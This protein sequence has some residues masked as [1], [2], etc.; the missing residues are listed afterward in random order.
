MPGLEQELRDAGLE[1]RIAVA[2]VWC[3]R[4]GAKYLEEIAECADTFQDFVEALELKPL[5]VRRLQRG[6]LGKIGAGGILYPLRQPDKEGYSHP[7]IPKVTPAL[8]IGHTVFVKNTFI[9]LDDGLRSPRLQ[10]ASTYHVRE[11]QADSDEEEQPDDAG[12]TDEIPEEA[13]ANLSSPRGTA[14]ELTDTSALYKTMTVDGYEPSSEWPWLGDHPTTLASTPE[15]GPAEV[16][17]PFRS[18]AMVPVEAYGPFV[19]IPTAGMCFPGHVSVELQ[20]FDRWPVPNLQQQDLPGTSSSSTQKRPQ[21][22]QRAFS[23]A[24]RICRIRWTVDARKLRST[25]R[26]AVSPPFDLSYAGPVTFKMIM[27]PKAISSERGGSCFKRSRGRGTIELRCMAESDASERP[28]VTFRIGVGSKEKPDKLRGPVRHDFS[29]KLICGLP[30]GQAIWDFSKT[31]DEVT[32]TFVVCLE[33]MSE[34]ISDG[35]TC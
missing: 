24:S 18:V 28:V 5:E 3:D 35:F 32:Q 4:M 17:T 13:G 15:E 27:R 8:P 34:G 33:I 6:A 26:E 11:K 2:A 30:D 12:T 1:S 29:E 22:L 9:D 21:V 25:D 7:E 19:P 31:V 20:R 14:A 23:V 16:P 10:R